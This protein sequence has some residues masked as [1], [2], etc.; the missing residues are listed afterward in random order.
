MREFCNENNLSKEIRETI[1]PKFLNISQDLTNELYGYFINQ[2]KKDVYEQDNVIFQP[3]DLI[4]NSY[5]PENKHITHLGCDIPSWFN[6]QESNNI[7][8]LG[9]DPLRAGRDNI[10]QVE[11]GTPYAFH[12]KDLREKVNKTKKYFDFIQQL[13]NE[14]GLYITDVAKIFYR[15]KENYAK[16][17]THDITF[18]QKPIHFEILKKEIEI[19]KPK[20]IITLGAV[21]A[22]VMSG[23][24]IKSTNKIDFKLHTYNKS[25]NQELNL[26]NTPLLCLPHLSNANNGAINKFL[27]NHKELLNYPKNQVE[28]YVELANKRLESKK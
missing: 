12:I 4:N 13:S 21:A 18:W 14:N 11:F 8:V 22:H 3:K 17:S 1:L 26:G 20:L 25:K 24:R 7:M 16:R 27:E 2:Y 23:K 10:N 15:L 9:L 28:S 19:I 6:L 5:L